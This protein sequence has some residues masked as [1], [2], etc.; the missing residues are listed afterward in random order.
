MGI[1][2]IDQDGKWLLSRRAIEPHKGMLDTIGGFVN[3]EE[4]LEAA[5][6]REI[7]EETGLLPEHYSP[8]TFLCSA[9]GHYPYKGEIITVLSS[10]FWAELHPGAKPAPSDDVAEVLRIDPTEIDLSNLHDDDIRQAVQM[11]RS[12]H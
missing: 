1:I 12:Q 11:L 2:L 9:V 5:L 10:F 6:V 3:S 4:T 8:P 7:H